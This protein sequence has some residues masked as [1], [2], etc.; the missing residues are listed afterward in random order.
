MKPVPAHSPAKRGPDAAGRGP[1]VWP[2]IIRSEVRRRHTP[3][4]SRFV[5]MMK[6]VLPALALA[7]IAL[8][9]VWPHLQTRDTRF[10]IG[11]SALKARETEDPSMLNARYLGTDKNSQVFSVTA[12]LAKNL[13][14][15]TTEVELEMPKADMT[16]DDGSWVVLTAE[17]GIYARESKTLELIGSVNLF[18]DSG[19]EFRTSRAHINFTEGSAEGNEPVEGQGPF[20]ELTAEGFRMVEKGRTIY[21]TGKSKVVIYPGLGKKD[22]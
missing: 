11:F 22:R 8:V 2:G 1:G 13:I 9:V 16:M 19:Y 4:Y 3:G 5:I 15:S 6:F 21:F 10:R 7:L 18:H 20:G 12:D 14:N 17:T